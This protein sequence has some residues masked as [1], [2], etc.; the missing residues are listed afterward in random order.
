MALGQHIKDLRIQQGL[1][2]GA[3]ALRVKID[4]TY[5]SKLENGR[6]RASDDVVRSLADALGVD[7]AS[8]FVLARIP[9]ELQ[10]TL[11]AVLPGDVRSVMS[12]VPRY[13][14]RLVGRVDDRERLHE[15][16][17]ADGALVVV[18][19]P[20]GGGKTRLAAEV[21][22]D[23]QADGRPIVWVPVREHESDHVGALAGLAQRTPGSVL[24]LDDA[25][26]DLDT[27]IA[28]AQQTAATGTRVVATTRQPFGIEGEQLL[29]LARLPVPDRH[30]RPT[31]GEGPPT[32]LRRLHEQE[33]VRLFLDRASLVAPSF[34]LDR[35]NAPVVFDVCR[36]LDGLPLAIELAALRLRLVTVADLA[37]SM[38]SLLG[39]LTARTLDGP[40]RHTSLE[41]AIGWSFD[42]LDDRQRTVAARLSLFES[43]FRID[44]A[45][46]V[47]ADE[48]L[49]EEFVAATVMELV[50]RSLLALNE[51][52][53]GRGAYRW[54]RPIR[55]YTRLRL[56]QAADRAQVVG[57]YRS[58]LQQVVESLQRDRPRSEAEWARLA[59]L[60]PELMSTVYRLPAEEQSAAMAQMTDALTVS[61]QF[62]N[63]AQH[64][65]WLKHELDDAKL[66]VVREAG[67]LARIRGEYDEAR[68]NFDQAYRIALSAGDLLGQANA[69]LDLAE[70][71]ADRGA[72]DEANGLVDRADNLY[73]KVNHP[74]GRIEVLNLRGKL[75]IE[76]R[77]GTDAQLLDATRRFQDA[78]DRSRA[79]EDSRLEAYSLHNLGVG[80]LLLRRITSARA[81]LEQSL[82]L[83]EGMRNRRGQ[84][85]VIEAFALVESEVQNHRTAVQLLGAV[86][87]YRQSSG[88]MG[89]PPW[90]REKL[91]AVV[92]EARFALARSPETVDQLLDRGRAM[93]L[94]EAGQVATVTASEVFD[95]A[96][97]DAAIRPL[98]RYV[99]PHIE[100]GQLARMVA[101]AGRAQP[102]TELDAAVHELVASRGGSIDAHRRLLRTRLLALADPIDA[103]TSDLLCFATDPRQY[104][105]VIVPVFSGG[106]ALAL[107]LDRFPEWESQ[108]VVEI[109]LEQLSLVKGETVVVNPWT[110]DE[111]RVSTGVD[112]VPAAEVESTSTRAPASRS[113]STSRS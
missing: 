47:A 29:P 80:D 25:D 111:Y 41:A 30:Q 55:Q 97:G 82:K 61:V 69:S 70:N 95:G 77:K 110:P 113:L 79:I 81:H 13:R 85:R 99:P 3:L 108:P 54:L 19:G 37:A 27:S 8:L 96:L 11:Q 15:M 64:V 100:S 102:E 9:A 31:R 43:P 14:T 4:V 52:A 86:Q 109:L 53:D 84:A 44:D 2:Q 98:R 6:R 83:R 34:Q 46:R 67:S 36:W 72:H 32:D 73:E 89:V 60:S 22:R 65:S 48:A 90:W 51:D 49:P 93:T 68:R 7:A 50:D 63:L 45:A 1:S 59:E 42:R 94:D 106:R 33:S 40:D 76:A 18:T 88:V 38:S 28:A 57:R 71:A 21:A 24:V 78:L 17:N 107:A 87:Q 16:L 66:D 20:P 23:L 112:Y 104:R 26:R 92:R 58:W 91:D 12:G 56:D 101:D 10:R 62:G 5:L 74:R 105:G 75:R 35:S 39:W 103:V